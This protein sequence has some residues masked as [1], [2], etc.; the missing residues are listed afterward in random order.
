MTDLEN[1]TVPVGTYDSWRTWLMTGARRTPV[2][3]RRMRGA[4]KGLKKILVEG[5]L[6]SAEAPYTWKDF[7]GAMVRHAVDDAMRA[8]PP[9]DTQVVKLAYFG[10]YSNREIAREIGLTEG[11]V[12][13]RLR[14]ALA[15]ISDHIQHGRVLGRRAFYALALWLSGRW[16]SDSAQHFLQA[17]AVAG[18]AAVIA[19]TQ[20]AVPAAVGSQRAPA[21]T[22]APAAAGT[23]V[24]PLPS[25]TVPVTVPG[26]GLQTV[27]V[28]APVPSVQVPTVTVPVTLPPLPRLP[29]KPKQV[30]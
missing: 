24:P 9:E 20:P 30:L 7:S 3:P 11:T 4:H 17:T 19:V 15:A 8:L 21:T 12:Q 22:Q 14:R 10:G 25:P 23:V 13:R 29:L 6:N 18:A 27:P 2:D 5:L 28:P 1:Q 16:L 26:E